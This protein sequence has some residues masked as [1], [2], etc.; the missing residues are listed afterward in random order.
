MKLRL[1][2]V[3]P[4]LDS[5]MVYP[6][7]SAPCL[8][9]SWIIRRATLSLMLPVGFMYS[10]FTQISAFTPEVILL[11]FTRGVLPMSC[12]TLSTVFIYWEIVGS[13]IKVDARLLGEVLGRVCNQADA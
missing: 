7:L 1:V 3:F 6:G 2:P 11:S 8:S 10:V 13:I 4:V 9:A 5:K 12:N